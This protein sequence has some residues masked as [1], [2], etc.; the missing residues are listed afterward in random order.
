[1]VMKL[2]HVNAVLVFKI[3]LLYLL[4]CIALHLIV[5]I[6]LRADLPTIKM[7]RR[8]TCTPNENHESLIFKVS[9]SAIL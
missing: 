5:Y 8:N 4:H 9:F 6:K 2:F 7:L 3:F 1:M